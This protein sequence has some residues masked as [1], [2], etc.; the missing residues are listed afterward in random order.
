MLRHPFPGEKE[1]PERLHPLGHD[2][3]MLIKD[4]HL[5]TLATAVNAN[6]IFHI[7]ALPLRPKKKEFNRRQ[8]RL[9]NIKI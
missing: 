8:M 2:N 7:K 4:E 5:S 6:K 1:R 9:N 3:S